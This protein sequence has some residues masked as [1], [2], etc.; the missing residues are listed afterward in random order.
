[1]GECER[2]F[3]HGFVREQ[4]GVGYV[5]VC[6]HV[7]DGFHFNSGDL[8][9]VNELGKKLS[10]ERVCIDREIHAETVVTLAAALHTKVRW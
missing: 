7:H 6:V 8:V 10:R 9:Y 3:L 1:M 2:Y 5:H 4:L